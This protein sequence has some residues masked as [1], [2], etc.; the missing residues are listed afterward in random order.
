MPNF[1]SLVDLLP[2]IPELTLFLTLVVAML[3]DLF[4]PS[5]RRNDV[6][7]SVSLGGIVLTMLAELQLYGA[8]YTGFYGTVVADDYSILMELVYLLIGLMTILLSRHYITENDMNFGEYYIL[9]LS[10]LIGMML[11]SSS[12]ELLVIFIGL[13]IMSIS[14]YILVGMKR[15]V[16]ESGEAA[17]KYLL[18]GAFS[19][20]FLLYGISLLYGATGSTYLPDMLQ[21]LRLGAVETPLAL[22]GIALL[23]IGLSFKV[24]IVPFHMWTPDVYSGAPTPVTGFMSAA[25]KAAGFTIMIRILLVGI[26]L[27]QVEGWETILG[28]LAVLT[29]TIGN[30]VALQQQNVKRMLAYSSIAHAGYMMVAIAVG[31]TAAIGSVLFYTLAYAVVSTGAF[32]ILAIRNRGRILE[33]YEDLHG[34]ARI[35]PMLALGMSLMMLSLIG[36]PLTGGFVGKLQIFGAA[37]EA[38]WILLTVVAVLNSALSV[39]YYLRVISCM[40]LQAGEETSTVVETPPRLASFGVGL[41]VFATLYLGIFPDDFLVLINESVRSLL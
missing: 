25:A 14:S 10:A 22:A 41:T 11:M 34:Y 31:T 12:L 6:L 33:T 27:E 32:G 36:L 40:Y 24:A 2:L 3:T 1:I 15:K 29:M 13:E 21:Q 7:V 23:T 5:N 17:L 18:L 26:P 37:L 19:T 28:W 38:D 16:P 8:G 30:L 35:N 20:G 9:L 39:Y 4:V